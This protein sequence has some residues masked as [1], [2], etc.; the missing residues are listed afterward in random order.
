VRKTRTKTRGPS[1]RE[2]KNALGLAVTMIIL[3]L[4]YTLYMFSYFQFPGVAERKGPPFTYAASIGVVT[5]G[6]VGAVLVGRYLQ[7]RYKNTRNK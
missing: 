7:S 5:L 1:W 6:I 2:S 3:F 4:G